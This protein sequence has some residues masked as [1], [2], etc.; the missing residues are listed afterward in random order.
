MIG[1]AGHLAVIAVSRN[2]PAVAEAY[3]GG[4]DRNYLHAVYT[5]FSFI[6]VYEVLLLVLALP[7]SHTSSIEKQY[8]IVSLIVI[9]RVF[10]DLGGFSDLEPWVEQPEAAWAVL[11]DMLGA[12]GMFVLVTAFARTRRTV[13]SQADPPDGLRYFVT[14]KRAVALLL[15]LL[16]VGL[17][18]LSV[19]QWLGVVLA[20]GSNHASAVELD[21]YFFPAFFEVMI[22][23]DVFLLIL[24]I[25]F[26][27]QY[28]LV[29]RNAGFVIS[30]VLLRASLA[31]PRPYDLGLGLLAMVYG[32]AILLVF[33]WFQKRA[34]QPTD[35]VDKDG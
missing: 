11:L 26:Y 2:A 27:D 1:F 7:R 22:F 18:V 29:F 35:L 24:S 15:G 20:P 16:L 14:I 28:E 31:S 25:A 33:R 6:L 10:K 30:T 23:T 32:L 34:A 8:Q 5:P 9:R 3:F 17:A 4:L 21:A 19:G 13:P 12:A